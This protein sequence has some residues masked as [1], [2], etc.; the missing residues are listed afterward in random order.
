[1]ADLTQEEARAFI[2][3]VRG[4]LNALKEPAPAE[5]GDIMS[6]LMEGPASADAFT[7]MQTLSANAMQKLMPM[8]QGGGGGGSE[9]LS[10]AK[11]APLLGLERVQT[12]V[13]GNT[14]T[15][16][17]VPGWLTV[18]WTEED[19]VKKADSFSF[20]PS[21]LWVI[22]HPVIVFRLWQAMKKKRSAL[23]AS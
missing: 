6:R 3:A 23:P 16:K 20:K 12:S 2:E 1:M 4:V 8:M 9:D 21:W 13:S 10:P 5:G 14:S 18:K 22:S 11:I 7:L 17:L 19:G 15:Y